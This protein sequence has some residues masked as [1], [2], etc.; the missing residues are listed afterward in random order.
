MLQSLAHW[1]QDQVAAHGLSAIFVLMVLESACIPIPSEVTMIY[2][3]YLVSQDQ[4]VFWQAVLVGAFANLVGS[5]IAWGVGAYGVDYAILR[6]E[7]NRGHIDQATRWFERYGNPVVFFSRMVPIVRTFI[8][9]PAGVAR[10][11]LGRFSVLTFLGCLPWC[12]A[13]VWIGDAAGSNWDTWHKRVGYL[14]DL[15]VVAAVAVV[16]WWLL[17]RR[18][19][20]AV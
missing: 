8:S 3:G 14:D 18:R 19:R 12:L 16:G 4:L 7:H 6:I 5:W 13:L 11:P 20:A 2:A 1:I 10:M 17:R 15:V 9:L